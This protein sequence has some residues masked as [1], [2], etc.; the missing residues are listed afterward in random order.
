MPQYGIESQHSSAGVQLLNSLNAAANQQAAL[1]RQQALDKQASNDRKYKNEADLRKM[2]AVPVPPAAPDNLATLPNGRPTLQGATPGARQSTSPDGEGY[3]VVE[4]ESKMP[5]YV[6]SRTEA[7]NAELN[8]TNSFPLNDE[9]RK[10][11]KES[12]IDLPPKRPDGTEVRVPMSLVDRLHTAAETHKL[13]HP[14][15]VRQEINFNGQDANGNTSPFMTDPTTGKTST[16]QLPPGTTLPGKDKPDLSQ[17]LQGVTGPNG[18]K[19]VF[20]RTDQSFSEVPLP[21]G[22]KETLTADQQDR[23]QD[24][25]VRQQEVEETRTARQ[26]T[27]AQAAADKAAK[28]VEAVKAK[29]EDFQSKE[30]DQWDLHKRF[31]D[32]ANPTLNKNG[33]TVVLPN[34]NPKTG[35]ITEGAPRIMNDDLRQ[36]FIAQANQAQRKALE[37]HQNAAGIRRSMKWGEFANQTPPP[38]GPATGAAAAAKTSNPTPAPKTASLAD[39]RAYAAKNNIDDADAIRNAKSEGYSIVP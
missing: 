33:D 15:P 16:V 12:D 32:L 7:A 4:P 3:T 36:S 29:H 31:A 23:R 38:Q 11:A 34:Y 18:G 14:E 22:T 37:Q 24:R 27:T 20:N 6:P 9:L 28:G 19:I 10:S 2:G 35:E 21:P 17:I 26:A 25:K 1:Q 5:W 13:Q 8:D 39:I 30:Q